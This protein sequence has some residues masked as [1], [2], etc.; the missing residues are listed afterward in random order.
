VAKTPKK[1][2]A[3]L[4]R[5]ILEVMPIPCVDLVIV[6]E[7]KFLLVKRK[8][9]PAAGR[10]CIPGGRVMKG[11][12]LNQAVI[13]IVKKETSLRK[14]K[15]AKVITASQFFSRTSAFGPSAHTISSVF[16]V[17]VPPDQSLRGDDQS[18]ELRWFSKIDKKWLKYARDMLRLAGFK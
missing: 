2:E 3:K 17:I 7:R 13:R 18:S 1:I 14:F 8:N 4:Y 11:E 15:I 12:T 5:K 6:S 16:L 9:K 10:W